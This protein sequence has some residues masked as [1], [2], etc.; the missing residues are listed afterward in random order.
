MIP[1]D[2]DGE[3]PAG[4][5]PARRGRRR[6]Q[7]VE[8]DPVRA[9]RFIRASAGYRRVWLRRRPS[10]G[11]PEAAP[12]PVRLQT[13]ADLAALDWGLLAWEDPY[14]ENGPVSPFWARGPMPDGRAVRD[15]APLAALAAAGGSTLAGLRLADGALVLKA[16]RPGA[17][18]QVRLPGGVAFPDDAG[19]E[20]VRAV[21]RIEDLWSG[22]PAP[23]PGRVRGPGIASCWPLWKGARRAG[24][25]RRSPR[26]SGAGSGRRRSISWAAGCIRGSRAG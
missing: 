10:P 19:L 12:F 8:W 9:W 16:E 22:V 6:G 21:V 1:E 5:G 14:A 25:T 7:P 17:A 15:A 20:L 11:L 4:T 26:R 3:P 23:R 13:A 18:V 2:S 24:R